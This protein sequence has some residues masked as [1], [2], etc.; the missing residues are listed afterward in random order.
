M[1][2]IKSK[3]D[4]IIKELDELELKYNKFGYTCE[5]A[6]RDKLKITAMRINDLYEEYDNTDFFTEDWV[7]LNQCIDSGELSVSE[8]ILIQK[9]QLKQ[10]CRI[11]DI[12]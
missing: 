4:Q 5:D 10:I 11:I 9:K 3:A 6:L 8:Y 1:T 7:G 12:F 2:M